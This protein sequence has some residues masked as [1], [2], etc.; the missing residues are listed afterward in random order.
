MYSKKNEINLYDVL[1]VKYNATPQ[2]IKNAYRKLIPTHHPDR[3]GDPELFELITHAFNIL[4]NPQTR[5]EYDELSKLSKQSSSDHSSLKKAADDF[6]KA[7]DIT[8]DEYNEQKTDAKKNYENDYQNLDRKHG[9]NRNDDE[10]LFIEKDEA[11]RRL[12]DLSMTREQDEIELT[13]E[14]LFDEGQ[15]NLAKFNALFDQMHK[16]NDELI[17]HSGNPNAFNVDGSNFSSYSNSYDA[18]YDETECDGN[19]ISSSVKLNNIKSTKKI[20]KHDLSNIKGAEYVTNHNKK[21]AVY[22]KSLEKLIKDRESEDTK[23][24]NRKVT[25]YDTDPN[26]AGYGIFAEVG[27][28]GKEFDWAIEPDEAQK[29]Y[30]KLLEL[31]KKK[32]N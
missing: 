26:M 24:D 18:L 12:K 1:G 25:D 7:Q 29:R 4:Y 19:A 30:N 9:Y 8:E 31:R 13:Q 15:F 14:R 23:F 32:K 6:F 10:N 11:Q 22:N 28:T 27:L 5:G 3:G 21:D 20:T 2:N 16:R 17:P